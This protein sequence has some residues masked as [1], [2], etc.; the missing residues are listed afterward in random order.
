MGP[1]LSGLVLP[2]IV[3]TGVSPSAKLR[4]LQYFKMAY[5]ETW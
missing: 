5:Q 4:R 1:H 3:Y 2:P